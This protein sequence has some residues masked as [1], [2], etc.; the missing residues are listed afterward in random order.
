[1]N[2]SQTLD[3]RPAFHATIY[4][5]EYDM[6]RRKTTSEEDISKQN[7]IGKNIAI[8]SILYLSEAHSRHIAQPHR[9][10]HTQ[11]DAMAIWFSALHLIFEMSFKI[12]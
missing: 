9:G 12:E 3:H 11:T 1:M 8:L 4:C 5:V 7:P 2:R 6:Q 10:I